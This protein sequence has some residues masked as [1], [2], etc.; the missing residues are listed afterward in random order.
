MPFGSVAGQACIHGRYR[1]K[2]MM[3]PTLWRKSTVSCL[4]GRLRAPFFFGKFPLSS[5]PHPASS[6]HRLA[7]GALQS[8]GPDATEVA[9]G[10]GRGAG[11]RYHD[12]ARFGPVAAVRQAASPMMSLA[13]LRQGASCSGFLG[14]HAPDGGD[15]C[16]NFRLRPGAVRIWPPIPRGVQFALGEGPR[17]E[18]SAGRRPGAG[19]LFCPSQQR[20]LPKARRP[21]RYLWAFEKY[22]YAN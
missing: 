17:V 18:E 12:E 22:D 7:L 3:T 1:I 4:Q 10:L 8:I 21:S 6:L 19:T 20:C 14:C 9:E 13:C 15:G 16:S 11:H 2:G 5:A